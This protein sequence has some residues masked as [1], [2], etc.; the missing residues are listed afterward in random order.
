MIAPLHLLEQLRGLQGAVECILRRVFPRR[1][2]LRQLAN[3]NLRGIPRNLPSGRPVGSFRLACSSGESLPRLASQRIAAL[4][5]AIAKYLISVSHRPVGY[6]LFAKMHLEPGLDARRISTMAPTSAGPIKN[7]KR[8][9]FSF[10][11]IRVTVHLAFQGSVPKKSGWAAP[12]PPD[13]PA[14]PAKRT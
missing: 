7:R 3:P 1:R 4:D 6:L 9:K 8:T 11:A 10:R 14:R 2:I 12:H 5:A 13:T